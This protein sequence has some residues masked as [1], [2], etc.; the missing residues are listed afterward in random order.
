MTREMAQTLLDGGFQ[1]R[2]EPQ[3]AHPAYIYNVFQGIPFEAAPTEAGKS[4][5]GYPWRGT[6]PRRILL[7]LR[8]RA[9]QEGF[10]REFD[11]WLDEHSRIRL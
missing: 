4:F 2:D 3:D 9:E 7:A 5:H 6:M 1:H 11:R 8:Q 10:A